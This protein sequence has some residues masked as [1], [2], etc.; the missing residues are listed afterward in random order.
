MV[1]DVAERESTKVAFGVL[2]AGPGQIWI[3]DVRIEQVNAD[4][5]TTGTAP[6]RDHPVNLD[7]GQ[8]TA[9]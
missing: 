3:A 2:L 1:L 4:V 5:P 6:L 8:R 7:F 9:S